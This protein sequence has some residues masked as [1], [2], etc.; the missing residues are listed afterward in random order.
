MK[1]AVTGRNQRRRIENS[2]RMNIG[3]NDLVL[4]P[5]DRTKGL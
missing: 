4:P 3:L 5:V 2:S 1:P